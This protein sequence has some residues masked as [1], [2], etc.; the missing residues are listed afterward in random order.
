MMCPLCGSIASVTETRASGPNI[1]RRRKCG[2]G[3]AITTFEIPLADLPANMRHKPMLDL[4]A[5]PRRALAAAATAMTHALGVARQA[6]PQPAEPTEP[7]APQAPIEP[8][9]SISR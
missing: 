7:E 2:N 8:G 4:V 9:T 1:R 6:I 3:H 5:I